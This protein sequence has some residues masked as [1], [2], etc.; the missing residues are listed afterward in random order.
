MPLLRR[1]PCL[2]VHAPLA[3]LALALGGCAGAPGLKPFTTDGCS[4]FPDRLEALGKDW[5]LCCVAHDRAYWRGGTEED[6]LKADQ[7]LRTC[8]R[9]ASDNAELAAQ[10]YA[11]VRIGGTAYLPTP[12]RW[13]YGWPYGRFYKPLQPD[14]SAAADKLEADY[15]ARVGFNVC[16]SAPPGTRQP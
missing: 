11:G 7:A 16:P 2:A 13:G 12:F 10:M 8:V 4:Q 5:C 15:A 9:T 3:A 6:R 1:L 14:E